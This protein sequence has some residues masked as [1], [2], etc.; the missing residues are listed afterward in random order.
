LYQAPSDGLWGEH[1]VDYI[2]FVQKNVKLDLNENEVMNH[3]FVD[4]GELKELL[5]DT[6]KFFTP[7][8]VR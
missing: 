6:S 1:E 3:C 5:E 2:L 4:Q 8:N 7:L